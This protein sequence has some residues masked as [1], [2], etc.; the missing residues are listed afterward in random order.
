[1]IG[2]LAA[3]GAAL[4]WAGGS[5][6]IK[7][8]SAQF[9]SLSLNIFR[10]CAAWL[11]LTIVLLP[12]GK[13]AQISHM[14]LPSLAYIIGSGIIGLALG[15]N[16]Y[17]KALSRTDISKVYPVSFSTWLLLTA[18]IAV[19]FLGEALTWLMVLGAILIVLG[20]VLLASPQGRKAATKIII[21]DAKG[22]LLALLTGLCWAIGASFLKL[23]LEG[24]DPLIVNF[25]RLPITVLFLVALSWQQRNASDLTKYS[26]KAL[27]QVSVSGILDQTIGAVLFFGAIKMIGVAKATM[28]TAT[29]PLFIAP[30][31][32]VLFKERLTPGI[33]LGTLCCVVG[34]W[35]IF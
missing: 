6:V 14:P 25:A 33:V 24:G 32:I 19:L 7:P 27:F 29:S 3:L 5:L 12:S 2:E 8:M 26:R 4:C 21:N 9:S 16:L 22:I 1:M 23:G 10:N 30:L 20:I 35:L 17:I 31:S 18:V 11:F 15:T 34:I 28:L 13:I